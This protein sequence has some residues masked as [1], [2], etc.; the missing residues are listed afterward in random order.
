MVT[1]APVCSPHDYRGAACDGEVRY[2]ED[3][4]N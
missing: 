1:A 2:S 3:I 4:A